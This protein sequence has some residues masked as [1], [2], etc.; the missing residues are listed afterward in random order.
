MGEREQQRDEEII[1]FNYAVQFKKSLLISFVL[2]VS[3]SYK[4]W[5]ALAFSLFLSSSMLFPSNL[6][7]H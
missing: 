5:M 4:D 7:Y 6:R 1:I 2:I 3:A